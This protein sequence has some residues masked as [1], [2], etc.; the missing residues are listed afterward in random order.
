AE[1]EDMQE[2]EADRGAPSGHSRKLTDDVTADD[3][4][5]DDMAGALETADTA[6]VDVRNRV[7]D[8]AVCLRHRPLPAEWRAGMRDIV[9]QDGVGV[10][11]QGGLDIVGVLGREV[12]LDHFHRDPLLRSVR[13]S[14]YGCIQGRS[15]P[16]GKR[17]PAGWG[18]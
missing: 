4:F 18:P 10:R 16:Q 3:R 14:R 7:Q 1:I 11:F 8:A 9:P 2:A 5:I 17:Q 15:T 12:A 6:E 13:L